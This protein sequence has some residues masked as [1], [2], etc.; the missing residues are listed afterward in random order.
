MSEHERLLDA[1]QRLMHH[2]EQQTSAINNLASSNMALI[3]AMIDSGDI[4]G[5]ESMTYMDGSR[6]G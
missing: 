2:I 6:I 5:E 3:Q 1:L 4:E